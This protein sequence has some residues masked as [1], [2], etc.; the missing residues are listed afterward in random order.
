MIPKTE[1]EIEA[2]RVSG[3]I[4][5][6]ILQWLAPQ[7]VAGIT[8]KELA[9]LAA[10][11]LKKLGGEPAFLGY[12][13]FPDVICIS[14][15]DEVV[16]GIPGNR[17]LQDGDIV[18]LDFGVRFD[19]MITDSAITVEVG[20]VSGDAHRLVVAT[21]QAMMAGIDQVKDGVHIGDIA[22]AIQARLDKDKLGVIE[23]LAGHGVGHELHEEPWV[24]NFGV[25][26]HGPVLHTG[27]TIA[28]EPMATLGSKEVA[29][30]TDGWT[31]S[32]FDGSLGAHFEH[33]VLITSNGAEILTL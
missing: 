13:G 24:P 27:M 23:D 33:T 6:N 3:Q 16:H 2:L 14:V 25:K 1:G 17:K 21:Q 18:G 10:A 12:R 22:A 31:I 30:G 7:T 9:N 20:T 8:T 28:I 19:G 4:L 5:S 11:E 26:G 29:W 32:T 15:N